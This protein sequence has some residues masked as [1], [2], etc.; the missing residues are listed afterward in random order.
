M[1]AHDITENQVQQQMAAKGII[2]SQQLA[3]TVGREGYRAT[4]AVNPHMY[5]Y[6]L[7]II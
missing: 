3:T 6:L 7:N 1:A 5:N 4:S 2:E